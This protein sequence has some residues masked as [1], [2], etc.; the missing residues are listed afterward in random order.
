MKKAL[1]V[2]AALLFGASL[3]AQD[4]E[5]AAAPKSA[6]A[7]LTEAYDTDYA[8]GL[9]TYLVKGEGAFATDQIFINA[10]AYAFSI[11]GLPSA[12]DVRQGGRVEIGKPYLDTNFSDVNLR[13]YAETTMRVGRV[14][15]GVSTRLIGDGG[16]DADVLARFGYVAHEKFDVTAYLFEGTDEE[17]GQGVTIPVKVLANF[18]FNWPGQAPQ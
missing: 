15:T 16:W 7:Q 5:P 8:V 12:L 11:P 10:E 6:L 2:L 9:G 14:I 1:I 13:L 18:R 4:A 17:T 3:Y